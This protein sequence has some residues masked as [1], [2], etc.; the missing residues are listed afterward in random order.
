VLFGTITV[1]YFAGGKSRFTAEIR[2]RA[3]RIRREEMFC[4]LF[5]FSS[6][7]SVVLSAVDS[8]LAS[9]IRHRICAIVY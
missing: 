2:Q 7:F 3:Q 4:I 8:L 1:T 6:V 5:L 9:R